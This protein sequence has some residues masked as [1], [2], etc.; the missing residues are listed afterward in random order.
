ML[1]QQL[2]PLQCALAGHTLEQITYLPELM[3]LVI[4]L[5]QILEIQLKY[6]SLMSQT[7]QYVSV[8]YPTASSSFELK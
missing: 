1:D 3:E 2:I 5:R 4:D 6:I 8:S 7:F